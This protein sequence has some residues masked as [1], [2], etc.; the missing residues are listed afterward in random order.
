MRYPASQLRRLAVLAALACPLTTCSSPSALTA[1]RLVVEAVPPAL[2]LTNQTPL[3]AYTFVIA[4]GAAAYTDWVPCRDPRSC[5]G[6][7]PG[8]SDVLSYSEIVGYAS[9]AREAIV[10]WW[11]LVPQGGQFQPDTVR[12]V[13]VAL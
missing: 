6:L 5:K 12:A 13:V 9:A 7:S 4:R 3:P 8:A 10:Y 1:G 2:H 11:H